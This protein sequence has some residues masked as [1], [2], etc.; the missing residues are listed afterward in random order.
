MFHKRIFI[1]KFYTRAF[2]CF[3]LFSML[4]PPSLFKNLP[5]SVVMK[6]IKRFL[7]FKLKFTLD[8][9]QWKVS[10]RTLTKKV[11]L[12]PKMSYFAVLQTIKSVWHIQLYFKYADVLPFQ[13]KK[14]CYFAYFAKG[15]IVMICIIIKYW[16]HNFYFY[17]NLWEKEKH[18]DF[19]ICF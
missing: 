7:N 15:M 11:F 13:V 14:G 2:Q 16:I 9:P 19:L 5:S 6:W 12:F 10:P 3:F 4:S 8:G 18:L 1:C 17:T